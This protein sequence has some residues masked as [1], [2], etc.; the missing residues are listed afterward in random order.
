MHTAVIEYPPASHQQAVAFW[1][2]GEVQWQFT[3]GYPASFE[4]FSRAIEGFEHLRLLAM[5]DHQPARAQWYAQKM[6]LL[7]VSLRERVAK[8]FFDSAV[9]LP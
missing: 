8:G 2:L 7:K 3:G 6:D 4:N 9:S 1:L 5:Y